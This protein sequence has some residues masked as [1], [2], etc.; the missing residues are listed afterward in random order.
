MWKGQ[1]VWKAVSIEKGRLIKVSS[2]KDGENGM[3]RGAEQTAI[4]EN[5]L[6]EACDDK[7]GKCCW[8]KPKG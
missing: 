6:V 8:Q 2:V 3:N 1:E 7:R 4:K 5:V